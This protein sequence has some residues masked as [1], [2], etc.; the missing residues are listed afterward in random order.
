MKIKK[1]VIPLAGRGTRF[2]PASKEIPK[3]MIPLIDRPMIHYAVEELINAGIEEIVFITSRDKEVIRDYFD[4]NRELENFLKKR[5]KTASLEL[6]SKI[7]SMANIISIRQQEPLGLGH[8]IACSRSFIGDDHF[9]VVLGDELICSQT[10]AI[11]QLI[12]IFQK[13]HTSVIGVMKVPKEDIHR[14]GIVEGTFLEN[15]SQT[16]KINQMEE[17]PS[18]S[19]SN[20]AAL[21]RYVFQPS[22]FDCL[23][24][25]SSG[26][27]DEYQLTDAIN[28]LCRQETAMAHLVSGDRFDTG[29]IHGFLNATVEYALRRPDTMENMKKIIKEKML[30]YNL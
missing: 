30:R 5:K 23:E 7:G 3:E 20:L 21:G 17:K 24:K 26:S 6:V 25:I 16:L 29:N 1:A 8:A 4:R 19:P 14:Y 18:T 15:D 28:L 2:L 10:S 13:H 9:A 12:D 11:D 22:I 27:N